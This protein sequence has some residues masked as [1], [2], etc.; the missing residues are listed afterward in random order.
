M[1]QDHVTGR[2]SVL[3]DLKRYSID[4][5]DALVETGDTRSGITGGTQI[6]YIRMSLER[7][8]VVR[9][10][11]TMW[12][13]ILRKPPMYETMRSAEDVHASTT[14]SDIAQ[15]RMDHH[16]ARRQQTARVVAIKMPARA[17]HIPFAPGGELEKEG[18]PLTWSLPRLPFEHLVDRPDRARASDG[19]KGGIVLQ[20]LQVCW[21]CR[22]PCCRIGAMDSG[23]GQ[24]GP[25]D[26]AHC[27]RVFGAEGSGNPD[28]A[29]C[30]KVLQGA[31]ML[32]MQHAAYSIRG[33]E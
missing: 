16:P 22:R 13:R 33:K 11:S 14:R 7:S 12:R 23:P 26:I 19:L 32:D 30:P 27:G 28:P 3:D 21:S 9:T 2:C 10:S 17:G 25:N 15:H 8:P 29:V 1:H 18:A 31:I 20:V 6:P 24:S 5:F 4:L